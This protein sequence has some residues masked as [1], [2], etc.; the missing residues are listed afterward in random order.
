MAITFSF[1]DRVYNGS[2]LNTLS[3]NSVLCTV[4]K[5][6]IVGGIGILWFARGFA[7]LKTYV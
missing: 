5:A 4:H 6:A 1:I 7:I 2:T 3:Q